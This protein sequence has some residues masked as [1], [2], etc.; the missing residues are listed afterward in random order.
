MI[1][2][3]AS[4]QAITGDADRWTDALNNA[5]IRWRITTPVRVAMFLAQCGHES[6]G[7]RSLV[8][9]L[10]YGAAGLRATW[11][12][13]FSAADA[14]A[15]ER[16]PERIAERAYGGRMGNGPEGSGDG[17]RYRGRGIIQLTGRDNYKRAGDAIGLDFVAEPELVARP[18][19]AAATAGWFW[20]T[21]GC[22]ALADVGDFL[23]ITKRINGGTN[24]LADRQ[25][26]L[27]KVQS[28]LGATAVPSPIPTQPAAPIDDRSPVIPTESPQESKPMSFLASLLPMVLQMFAPR[29]EAALGKVSGNPTAATALMTEIVS[30]G[31]KLL[32]IPV[33]QTPTDEQAVEVVAALKKAQAE[34]AALVQQVEQHA[35]DYL[36]KLAPMFD[37][38]QKADEWQ[39]QSELAGRKEAAERHTAAEGDVVRLVVKDVTKTKQYTL[40]T[41]GAAGVAAIVAKAIV[42]EIPDYVTP[43]IA[44]AGPLVGQVMKESG[45]VIA[46][47]FDGTPTSNA[48]SAINAQI[49]KIDAQRNGG[50]Q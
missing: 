31:G 2:D 40:A 32:G 44:L 15:M 47:Y 3:R 18:D 38:L 6:G 48:A 37:K 13:R 36:D 8:E 29:A 46:Y 5:C 26:W 7:F 42:P 12:T 41:I 20:A 19:W 17:Y 27:A 21:N 9:N 49:A 23:A 34:N 1:L 14:L 10:N 22:N 43:L 25:A 50:S 33:G 4:V 11:P 28:I 35:L 16:Q 24:G 30:Q 45:A 39:R